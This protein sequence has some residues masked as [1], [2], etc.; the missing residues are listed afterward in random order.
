MNDLPFWKI[1]AREIKLPCLECEENLL[2]MTVKAEIAVNLNELLGLDENSFA[3]RVRHGDL[4]AGKIFAGSVL[5]VNRAAAPLSGKPVVVEINN[6]L[7][8]VTMFKQESIYLQIV[9]ARDEAKIIK[10]N[11]KDVLEIWGVVT[12]VINEP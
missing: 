1:E 5:I 7:L 3:I 10:I 8:A 2:E 11:K 6:E 4:P 9:P 12:R